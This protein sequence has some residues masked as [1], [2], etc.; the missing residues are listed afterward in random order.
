MAYCQC[1]W[2]ALHVRWWDQVEIVATCGAASAP[3]A[4]LAAARVGHALHLEEAAL[5]P[6]ISNGMD[7][8][9]NHTR[10]PRGM[11]RRVIACSHAVVELRTQARRLPSW[12]SKTV[13]RG[14]GGSL[15]QA[16]HRRR[17]QTSAAH[18]P[19]RSP[20]PTLSYVPLVRLS[21]IERMRFASRY[22]ALC[23]CPVSRPDS[24]RVWGSLCA[25]VRC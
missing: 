8:K 4:V 13:Y 18:L 20:R 12:L 3:L 1:K 19:V 24:I 23:K 14:E 10:T 15:R 22:S 16:F 17:D 5:A 9:K 7:A 2:P 6:R 11:Q 25:D 21:A